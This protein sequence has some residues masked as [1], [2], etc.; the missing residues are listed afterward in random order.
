MVI[1]GSH[2]SELHFV[3]RDCVS[4]SPVSLATQADSANDTCETWTRYSVTNTLTPTFPPSVM[5]HCASSSSVVVF[6]HT[7]H[8]FSSLF[9]SSSSFLP[10]FFCFFFLFLPFFFLF[11]LFFFR[12]SFFF[13]SSS[14]IFFFLLLLSF[15]FLLPFFCFVFLGTAD[16]EIIRPSVSP[17]S[18]E[19]WRC[20]NV[21]LRVSPIGMN[22]YLV[23]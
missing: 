15:F 10:L 4:Y 11:F 17:K 7:P 9:L 21:A 18:P 19:L 20:Q 2:A 5:Y 22:I 14:F 13:L 6:L 23:T 3:C 16:G 1:T 8:L 12:F